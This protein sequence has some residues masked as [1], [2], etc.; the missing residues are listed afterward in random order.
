MATAVTVGTAI[1][2]P[3]AGSQTKALPLCGAR[4][5]L[6]GG[7]SRSRAEAMRAWIGEGLPVVPDLRRFA[8]LSL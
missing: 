3:S 8:I 7:A 6:G 4:L 1:S 5:W 2:P